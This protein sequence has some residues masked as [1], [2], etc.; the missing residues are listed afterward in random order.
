TSGLAIPGA[1]RPLRALCV[2]P[3]GMEEGTETDV[4]SDSVGLVVGEPAQFRF[5]SS[6][7]RKDDRPGVVLNSW[8]EDE[9]AETDSLEA[10]L[11]ADEGAEGDY[12]PVRF[13]SVITELGV[14]ELWCV[15]EGGDRRWK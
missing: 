2:V 7:V 1:P 4:P 14:F 11:P 15:A 9:L 3:A 5:F 13:H 12:V 6:A 10:T 8:S